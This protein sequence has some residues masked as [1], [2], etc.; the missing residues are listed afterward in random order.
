MT[1]S[2]AYDFHTGITPLLVIAALTIVAIVGANLLGSRSDSA[3]VARNVS[4]C[5]G[6]DRDATGALIPLLHEDSAAAEWKL[7]QALQ[8][9]RRAR[10]HC[11]GGSFEVASHHYNSLIQASPILTGSAAATP[12][13]A[14]LDLSARRREAK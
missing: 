12:K 3:V 8:Q 11:R 9:L 6:L 5:S 4:D 1:R 13:D 14:G 2:S 10:R 7:D